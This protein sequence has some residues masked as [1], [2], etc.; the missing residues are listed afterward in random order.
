VSAEPSGLTLP[1]DELLAD[2]PLV[3]DRSTE[4]SRP[5]IEV[6]PW[7]VQLGAGRAGW[8]MPAV[9]E[10][11]LP[12]R[13]RALRRVDPVWQGV[14]VGDR[15]PDYGPGGWFEALVVDAPHALVWWS[16]RGR[17]LRYTWALVLEPLAGGASRLRIRLR[18]SRHI[19]RSVSRPLLEGAA[20]AVDWAFIALM[21]AG[22]RE[23]IADLA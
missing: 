5:P 4:F 13:G 6:W 23:R 22:L 8:Y 10:R 16:E 19:G 17:D 11:L 9:V 1:G 7:L 18:L 12:A 15:V 2:A 14:S 21:L 20:D 3:W